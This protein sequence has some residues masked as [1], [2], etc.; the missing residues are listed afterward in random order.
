MNVFCIISVLTGFIPVL[1]LFISITPHVTWRLVLYF[2]GNQCTPVRNVHD[3][4]L[5]LFI[6]ASEKICKE[7]AKVENNGMLYRIL[8]KN[9]AKFH[10]FTVHTQVRTWTSY[11]CTAQAGYNRS[12]ILLVHFNVGP[13]SMV[14]CIASHRLLSANQHSISTMEYTLAEYT[15]NL[16]CPIHAPNSFFFVNQL[17]KYVTISRIFLAV[18]QKKLVDAQT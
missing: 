13:R 9:C 14:L 1:H 5:S 16:H 3:R 8:V 17:T 18:V 15:A 4:G 7:G 12:P 11:K 6:A 2:Q 10:F